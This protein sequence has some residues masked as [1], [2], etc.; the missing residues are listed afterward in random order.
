MSH[1]QSGKSKWKEQQCQL[2]KR[3]SVL[4]I[5]KPKMIATKINQPDA[6]A[7]AGCLVKVLA[8]RSRKTIMTYTRASTTKS[9]NAFPTPSPN[10]SHGVSYGSTSVSYRHQG[11]SKVMYTT[12]QNRS[13]KIHAQVGPQPKYIAAKIGPTIGP[14]P[15]IEKMMPE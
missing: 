9:I 11:T 15:A 5:R 14:A 12:D 6:V 2:T 10:Q 13:T 3:E 4:R 8:V 7:T 1:C